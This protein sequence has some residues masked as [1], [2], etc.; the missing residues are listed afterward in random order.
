MQNNPPIYNKWKGN[1]AMKAHLRLPA[2]LHFEG[3][4]INIY[5]GAEDT[6]T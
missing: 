3:R 1:N 4:K 5:V 6:N 2:N